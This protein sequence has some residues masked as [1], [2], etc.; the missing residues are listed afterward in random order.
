[1]VPSPINTLR[2]QG[3]Y[4]PTLPIPTQTGVNPGTTTEHYTNSP[5][6]QEGKT[7]RRNKFRSLGCDF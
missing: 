4:P 1:M 6:A 7:N 3:G 5:G 2:S